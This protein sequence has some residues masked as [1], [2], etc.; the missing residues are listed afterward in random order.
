MYHLMYLVLRGSGDRIAEE[1][2]AGSLHNVI[3]EDIFLK[4]W[5]YLN[6]KVDANSVA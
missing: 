4:Y 2:V 6:E 5:I 1:R 3:F